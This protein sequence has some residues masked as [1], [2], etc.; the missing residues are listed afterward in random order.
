MPMTV[1]AT[2]SATDPSHYFGSDASIAIGEANERGGC[3][4]HRLDR[5]SGRWGRD[6]DLSV[7]N[8]GNV[9]LDEIVVTDSDS[10][11]T[12]APV[13]DSGFNV[14]DTNTD[15]K[16]DLTE[17]W[18]IRATGTA[19]AGQYMNTGTASGADANDSGATT[20]ATDP[21]HYFGSDASIAIEKQTNGGGCGFTDGPYI[22]VDGAVTWTYLVSNDGNVAL[23]EIVVTDSDS[24]VTPAPVLDSGFNVGDTNTD[25]K[26][27]LTET[28]QY[29]ATG[30]AEAG[31]YM[32]TG[33]ASGADA[34]D[35][36]ATT[37]ATDPSHYF[38]FGCVDCDREANERG[39][40]GF[41]DW[42]VYPGRWGRDVDL[43]GLERRQRCA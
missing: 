37:S 19:E 13:L 41:T 33:T 10:G 1:A 27:D 29:T 21:S 18:H 23:D 35:S 40:C 12:P 14:G 11:V 3:G 25:N 36:G 4:L 9:A 24:G 2:T 38:W 16:L 20:S 5:I 28:W 6:V 34:N 22:P 43:S 15:N 30:T 7:S 8:D 26:L 31:Q 32:N 39:G 17:T 42:T